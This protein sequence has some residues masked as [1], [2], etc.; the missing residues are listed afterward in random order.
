M[1]KPKDGPALFELIHDTDPGQKRGES[2]EAEDT[3][4]A[5]RA[6][7]PAE[8]IPPAADRQTERPRAAG[9]AATLPLFEIVGGRLRVA[10]TSRG[11]A[12][13]VFGLGVVLLVAYRL[14]L[15]AG[16]EQGKQ[17][18]YEAAV[19]DDIQA[20]RAEPPASGL[21]EGV[22][23]PPFVHSTPPADAGPAADA[24][25]TGAHTNWVTGYTYLAVQDFR[26]DAWADVQAAQNYLRDNGVETVVV[27][28]DDEWKYQLVTTQGFNR[29]DPVQRRL[30]DEF[31]SRVHKLGEAFFE[32]GG[33]YRLEGYFKKLT[34]Q[35][36]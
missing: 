36:W 18:G 24:A 10:L 30:A 23:Q 34:G 35:T 14:G 7:R 21:F 28:R 13:L 16:L 5:A 29:D 3:A 1:P 20:A 22:G 32:A 31:R 6:E 17:V 26:A 4:G 27:E 12:L 15:S 11:M 33:R 2:K 8:K 9:E 25:P 19:K